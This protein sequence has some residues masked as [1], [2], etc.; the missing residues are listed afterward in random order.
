MQKLINN[1]EL[2]KLL[3]YTDK[4][5]LSH[6]ALTSEQKQEFVFNKLIR[7]IPKLMP[8]ETSNSTVVIMLHDGKELEN[9][10][11]RTIVFT[12]EVFV[13]ITQWLIKDADLRP[14]AIMG[15]IMNSLCGATINGLGHIDG[16]D[17]AYNYGT[18]E[19]TCYKMLFY[20][21]AYA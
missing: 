19:I 12:I 21:T 8:Q 11:F 14:F 15:E 18:D 20:V 10:E 17:F 4:D 6:E 16:G 3:Y 2:I 9:S 5:P 7:V 13:P 1:D